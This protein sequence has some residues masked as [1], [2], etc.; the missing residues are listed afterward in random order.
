MIRVFFQHQG[1]QLHPLSI[2]CRYRSEHLALRTATNKIAKNILTTKNGRI[3]VVLA[4]KSL[5]ASNALPTK[6]G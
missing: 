2:L 4:D 6:S 1:H 5:Y 3:L